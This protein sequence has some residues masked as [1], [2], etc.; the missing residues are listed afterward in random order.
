MSKNDLFRYEWLLRCENGR[1]DDF[2][3]EYHNG[4]RAL[5]GFDYYLAHQSI[6]AAKAICPDHP[7]LLILTA[8]YAAANGDITE[9]NRIY[10]ALIEQDENDTFAHYYRGH[11]HFRLGN[12]DQAN[13]DFGK[14]VVVQHDHVDVLFSLGK[15]GVS[16][17][18]YE[19]AIEHL[20]KLRGLL[21]QDH[22]VQN[23]LN[24]AHHFQLATLIERAAAD[25]DDIDT[26]FKLAKAYIEL[27]QSEESY[28]LLTEMEA[29]NRLSGKIYELLCISLY[30]QGK[31]ELAYAK[32]NEALEA[33]P[34]DYDLIVFK[35]HVL[36]EF[37][38]YEESVHCYDEAAELKPDAA[39]IY[40]NK[41]YV[42]NKMK[43]HNE[44]L[45]AASKAISL[46]PGMS[47]AFKNKA[48]ALLG[49]ELYGECNEACEEAL[50]LSPAFTE[51]IVVQMKL[52]T[53]VRQYED[54]LNKF[55]KAAE[56]GL[57]DSRLY[58]Q[59]ANALY[60][61]DR[62]AEAIE[63]CDLALELDE[64]NADAYFCKGLCHYEA[65]NYEEAIRC[66][67]QAI[68]HNNGY[69][70]A[71]FYKVLAFKQLSNFD[72]ALRTAEHAIAL[73]VENRD[74]FYYTRGDIQ[75]E[76]GNFQEAAVEYEKTIELN[77]LHAYAF[78]SIGCAYN[79]LAN[80]REALGYLDRAIDLDPA[81]VHAYV[82]KGTS[83]LRLQEY[84]KCVMQSR[85]AL[86]LDPSYMVAHQNRA[87]ALYYLDNNA[88]AEEQCLNALKIDG[89]NLSL[90]F[91][92][93]VLL[94]DR[95]AVKE[96]LIVS[97]RILELYPD[98]EDTKQQR[99]ELMGKKLRNKIF[100]LFS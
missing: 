63:Y 83:H 17:G 27:N 18:N 22:E 75:Y 28:N 48:E 5:D 82:E 95:D 52:L 3:T 92:K 84:E 13:R 44:A 100:K 1:Q 15:C 68:E 21:P 79:Q 94:K 97:D 61:M 77:P 36:D 65:N 4:S 42:L 62:N 86:D 30:Q 29:Q 32:V 89:E 76:Q 91:L 39:F 90:L 60:L 46:E 59:K 12:L 26:K 85:A 98:D 58:Y 24:S 47:H 9:A 7:D 57:K 80:N 54:V 20:N 64:R 43:K 16:L 6:N 35:A 45:A 51:A 53:K 81:L 87:W 67:N 25:P 96:A 49:L 71:Y 74:K 31:Q 10:T 99:A 33:Y 66:F 72:E 70:D 88:V 38:H 56:Y 37:G 23:L 73:P 69:A 41:A 50:S 34:H 55:N 93:M 40:N 14:A 8:R 11:L 2:I 19:A 78:Y